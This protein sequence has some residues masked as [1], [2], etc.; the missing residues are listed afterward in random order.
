MGT[1]T[2]GCHHLLRWSQQKVSIL[3]PSFVNYI[4][5][6]LTTPSWLLSV[7]II[8]A[9]AP[10][11]LAFHQRLPPFLIVECSP[12]QSI[13]VSVVLDAFIPTLTLPFVCTQKSNKK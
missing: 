2:W 5:C 6:L 13:K 7:I 11:P 3:Y 9:S 1:I 10:T 12:I 4:E 8:L